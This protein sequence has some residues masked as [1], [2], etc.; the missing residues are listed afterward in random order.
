M[1]YKDHGPIYGSFRKID[2]THLLSED[3]EQGDLVQDTDKACV[4]AGEYGPSITFYLK[5]GGYV[6][7]SLAKE[8]RGK[9]G[10]IINV[11]TLKCYNVQKGLER[12]LMMVV[13]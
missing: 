11:N 10:E 12:H 6:C 7:R 1:S 3:R 13:E 9:I 5:D 2:E 8:S 4:T